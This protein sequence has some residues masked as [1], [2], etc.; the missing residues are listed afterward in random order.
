MK[1]SDKIFARTKESILLIVLLVLCI[2]KVVYADSS[3][4]WFTTT[5]PYQLLPFVAVLTIVIEYLMIKNILHIQNKK[6]VLIA[7]C[8]SNLVSFTFM[9]PYFAIYYQDGVY[10][11]IKQTFESIDFYTINSAYLFLTLIIECPIVY[12]IVQDEIHDKKKSL[13][14]IAAANVVTT[15]MVAA[16]ERIACRGS[17]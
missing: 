12:A 11:T 13:G 3:W 14:V 15:V 16:I 10:E 8:I 6:R 9:V 1:K 2:P 17:W 5:A 4:I 7:V